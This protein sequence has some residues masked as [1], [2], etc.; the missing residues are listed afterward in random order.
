MAFDVG[1]KRLGIA[2]SDMTGRIATPL[3]VVTTDKVCADQSLLKRMID[4]YEVSDIVVGLP[5][6]MAGTEGPQAQW[7]RSF[8]DSHIEPYGIP[9][10]YIDERLSSKEAKQ[11]MRQAGTPEK[12]ARGSVDMVAAA[13]LLQAYLDSDGCD[14]DDG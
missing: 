7:V 12:K 11:A 13:L 14:S 1:Q 4:D 8:A 3:I 9:I 5:K 2:V 6:T 10:H